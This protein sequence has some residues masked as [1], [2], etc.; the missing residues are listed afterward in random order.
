MKKIALTLGSILFTCMT[1]TGQVFDIVVAKDG[2]GDFETLNAAIKSVPEN[3]G[4]KTIFVRK[5]IYEEKVFIGNRWE[6]S[7]K[8]I[9][10]I[11]EH[12]DSVVIT[13]NDYNG[14]MISYPGKTELISA[15]GMTCPTFTVTSPDFYMENITVQNPATEAQAV[16]LYQTGDRHVLKNC[17][18]VGNQDTYRLKKGRRFFIYQSIIE[19]GVDFI[20]AG[21]TAYFYKCIINSNR[22]GYITAPEDIIYKAQLSSGKTLRYGF[23]FND[24]DISASSSLAPAS[25]YLGRPWGPECGSVFIRCRL[26]EHINP[27]GWVSW[28]GNET[29]ACFAEFQNMNADGTALIDISQRVN[30]SFQISTY[31]FNHFMM[32]SHIYEAVSADSFDPA[33]FVVSPPPVTGIAVNGQELSW[34]PVTGI[35]GYVIYANGLAIGFAINESFTD[36][37]SYSETPAYSVRSVGTHGNLSLFDGQADE[38]TEASINNAINS[39]IT[40]SERTPTTQP[41][42]APHLINGIIHFDSP[43]NYRIYSI[44]GQKILTGNRMLSCDMHSFPEGIYIIQASDDRNRFYTTKIRL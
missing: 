38:I 20:Y 1:G 23:F 31:D 16:A 25:V 9:S 29:S 12:P 43:T 11:G 15:D 2:S 19:G 33:P 22:N 40:G 32:L 39:P 18:I 4:R 30:W 24:C 6:T 34:E 36:S 26:G 17:R 28:G 14:K 5:G 37:L 44:T 21:G 13:W 42:Y 27:K 8:I 10:L 7:N 3:S 35:K 41:E